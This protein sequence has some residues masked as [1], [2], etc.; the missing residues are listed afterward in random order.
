MPGHT[1]IEAIF[2][3]DA[4]GSREAALEVVSLG[5]FVFESRWARKLDRF[6]TGG[7]LVYTWLMGYFAVVDGRVV[8]G[9][10]FGCVGSHVCGLL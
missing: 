10:R 5:V 4:E 1:F 6:A 3:E 2:A 7:L 9:C 8:F